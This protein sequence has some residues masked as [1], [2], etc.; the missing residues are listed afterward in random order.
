MSLAWQVNVDSL[1]QIGFSAGDIAVLAGA[2][3]AIV[4]W[5]TAKFKDAALF[6]YLCV[7][8]DTLI[9]RTGLVDTT[10]LKDRWGKDL[11]SWELNISGKGT[12]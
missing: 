8:A 4:T 6:E 7:D 9:E 12:Q 2:G 1:L 11:A 10:E 3:R 5:L